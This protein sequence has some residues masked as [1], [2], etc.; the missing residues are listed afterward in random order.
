MPRSVLPDAYPE[1][2]HRLAMTFAHRVASAGRSIAVINTAITP[3]QWP[4]V[5]GCQGARIARKRR[6]VDVLQRVVVSV[7]P[8]SKRTARL[9]LLE[10]Q[11]STT[12]R[13]YHQKS[14]TKEAAAE[15]PRQR[16]S[17]RANSTRRAPTERRQR[18]STASE[19]LKFINS[20]YTHPHYSL[21]HFTVCAAFPLCVCSACIAVRSSCGSVAAF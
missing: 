6:V 3:R 2:I 4:F 11:E 20:S 12:R 17:T 8:S 21:K 15:E 10:R 13:E 14:T 18:N 7:R 19:L 1:P 16:N 9:E 5:Y